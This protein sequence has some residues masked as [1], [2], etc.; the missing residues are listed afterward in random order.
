LEFSC[1]NDNIYIEIE[2]RKDLKEEK[3]IYGKKFFSLYSKENEDFVKLHIKRN[4]TITKIKKDFFM[5]RYIYSNNKYNNKY[6]ISNPKLEVTQKETE[7][8]LYN[9]SIKLHPV[10]YS[11][12]YKNI[13]LTYIVRGIHNGNEPIY[14]SLSLKLESQ[15][16]KEFYDPKPKVNLLT[17]ELY[18]ISNN[19]SYIQVIVQIKN[20]ENVEYLSY[21]FQNKY[22]FIKYER[23]E[24]QKKD[25]S[26]KK[27]LTGITIAA[28]I[29][30]P[31]F[32]II[33]VAL[34]IGII[35]YNK[36]NKNLLEQVNKISFVQDIDR[37]DEDLLLSKD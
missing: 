10:E 35:I 22:T 8:G 15:T 28:I 37:S 30:G 9:Y 36:K 25:E 33:I 5:F 2:N 17:F 18:D 34:I 1:E 13:Y 26:P 12:E 20:E 14:P 23:K 16:V 27:K 11:K 24:S 32:F 6:S 31:L 7:L 4:A 19:F 3:N 29:L 21:D